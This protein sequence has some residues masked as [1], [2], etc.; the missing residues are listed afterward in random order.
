[1]ASLSA[2]GQSLERVSP[3]VK[4]RKALLSN[5]QAAHPMGETLSCQYGA[6]RLSFLRF[7]FAEPSVRIVEKRAYTALCSKPQ[8]ALLN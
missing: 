3:P 2:R 6:R 4:W 1:M 8:E 5:T 7:V